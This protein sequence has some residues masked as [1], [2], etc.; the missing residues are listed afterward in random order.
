MDIPTEW[1]LGIIAAMGGLIVT[2]FKWQI[3]TLEK[4]VDSDKLEA[5]ERFDNAEKEFDERLAEHQKHIDECDED[6]KE[7]REKLEQQSRKLTRMETLMGVVQSCEAPACPRKNLL[8]PKALG[9]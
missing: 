2:G 5:R 4:R 8:G 3:S 7:Q 1:I 9:E 6:R